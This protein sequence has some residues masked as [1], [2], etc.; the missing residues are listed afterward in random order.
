MQK[1]AGRLAALPGAAPSMLNAAPQ[2]NALFSV[3]QR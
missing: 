1:P 2:R 3:W